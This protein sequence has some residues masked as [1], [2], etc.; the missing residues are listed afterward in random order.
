M[1]IAEVV[2]VRGG[3]RRLP[4]QDDLASFDKRKLV[5][6]FR[7]CPD[8]VQAAVRVRNNFGL[9]ELGNAREQQPKQ[10]KI[11]AFQ[12]GLLSADVLRSRFEWPRFQTGSACFSPEKCWAGNMSCPD[13][14]WHMS[15][16][17]TARCNS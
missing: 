5:G 10:V 1:Q 3:L 16:G 4:L 12:G 17:A 11:S 8:R 7:P 2:A 14:P 15:P 9:E 13:R 6:N